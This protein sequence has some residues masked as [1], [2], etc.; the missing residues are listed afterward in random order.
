MPIR[1]SKVGATCSVRSAAKLRGRRGRTSCLRTTWSWCRRTLTRIPPTDTHGRAAEL[2][3]VWLAFCRRRKLRDPRHG[4]VRGQRLATGRVSPARHVALTRDMPEWGEA[5]S[6]DYRGG[7]GFVGPP[8]QA[9]GRGSHGHR[10]DDA[11]DLLD[12]LAFMASQPLRIEQHG[13]LQ[14]LSRPRN[15]RRT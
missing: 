1:L 11:F 2:L 12:V 8:A 9:G 15:S 4:G 14:D 6:R 3:R 10:V 13:P 7:C 5:M